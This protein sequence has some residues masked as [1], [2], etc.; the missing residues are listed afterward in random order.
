M[1]GIDVVVLTG[2]GGAA[3]QLWVALVIPENGEKF[4]AMCG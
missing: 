1:A 3:G 4:E 2:C